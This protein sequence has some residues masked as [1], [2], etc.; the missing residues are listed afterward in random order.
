MTKYLWVA[1]I[2]SLAIAEIRPCTMRQEAAYVDVHPDKVIICADNKE[3]AASELSISENA[4]EKFI[5]DIE[6]VRNLRYPILVLRPGSERLQHQLLQIIRKYNVD[7]GIEPWESERPISRDEFV[8]N[9]ESAIGIKAGSSSD[10][11][12]ESV[13]QLATLPLATPLEANTKGKKPVYYECR[14]NQ[15]FSISNEQ[16]AAS[17]PITEGYSF[18]SPSDETDEMWFG[19]KLAMVNPQTQYIAFFVR[20]DSYA[21]F[22]KARQL[23]W[24][25]NLESRCELLDAS[26]PLPIG[27]DVHLLVPDK[28]P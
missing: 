18:D 7:I 20:P 24:Y 3:I 17:A 5:Q 2:P 19:S 22:R 26:G 16:P 4:F 27:A 12:F 25:K 11:G 13:F 1:L 15:L 23:T 28:T 10:D 14:N 6:R 21:I 9:A 8:K